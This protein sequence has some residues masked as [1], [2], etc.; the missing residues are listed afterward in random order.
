VLYVLQ[1]IFDHFRG[2]SGRID[3]KAARGFRPRREESAFGEAATL[4]LYLRRL[5][6]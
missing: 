5:R 1:Q 2:T 6:N 3:G 4:A